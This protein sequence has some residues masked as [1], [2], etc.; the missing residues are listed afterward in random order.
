MEILIPTYQRCDEIG[1]CLQALAFQ[2]VLPD[3]IT[4][5]D[6]GDKPITSNYVVRMILDILSEKHVEVVYLRENRRVPIVA[7]RRR[8]LEKVTQDFM[9][10]DDDALLEPDY[11]E[12][13]KSSLKFRLQVDNS[14]VGFSSGLFLL[15]NNEIGK[16]D[17][18]VEFMD[19]SILIDVN[20]YQY[21][22]FRYEEF[23]FIEVDYGGV[24]GVLF[25]F[26]AKDGMIVSLENLPDD[27]P[28]EDFILTKAAGR[29]I[30]RTD[31][32]AWHLMNPSQH[33]DWNYALENILRRNFEKY[34]DKV[35]NFLREGA[36]NQDG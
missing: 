21:A 25:R 13:V 24:S 8:L 34:P 32:I 16:P 20:Q 4:I 28:L 14:L 29:G 6:S 26:E 35:V 17:F 9:F 11:I 5:L 12:K 18:S 27:S 1:L 3:R 2:R 22:F 30:L 10:V 15:P 36:E 33:R 7:A 31:A 23:K 19:D